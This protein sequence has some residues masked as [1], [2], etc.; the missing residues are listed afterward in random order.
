MTKSYYVYDIISHP[1]WV[2]KLSSEYHL[3]GHVISFIAIYGNYLQ[4]A[5]DDASHYSMHK[6]SVI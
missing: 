6:T 4:M 1:D 2:F 5:N 3:Y